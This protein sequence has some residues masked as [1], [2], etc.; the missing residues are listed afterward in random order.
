[1]NAN[2]NRMSSSALN[3]TENGLLAAV[4]IADSATVVRADCV[5]TER[6]VE[7]SLYEYGT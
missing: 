1:M 3:V 6:T 4:I 2:S 7:R 5:R